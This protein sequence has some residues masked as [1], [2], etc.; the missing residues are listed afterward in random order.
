VLRTPVLWPV[1]VGVKVT[2]IVHLT[3]EP[4]GVLPTIRGG[5]LLV[6]AKSPDVVMLGAKLSTPMQLPLSFSLQLT[7]KTVL[8]G[9]LVVPTSWSRKLKL[10]GLRLLV[11]VA[12]LAAIAMTAALRPSTKIPRVAILRF[13]SF[14]PPLI[15]L[16]RN[17]RHS[18]PTNGER[19]RDRNTTRNTFF[20]SSRCSRSG[21]WRLLLAE[22]PLEMPRSS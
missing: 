13:I 15:P 4:G 22:N 5:Q 19:E 8:V 10:S 1:P 2:L 21:A 11:A 3:G 6:C 14:P 12:G 17:S 18:T 9:A 16:G 7:V 20:P